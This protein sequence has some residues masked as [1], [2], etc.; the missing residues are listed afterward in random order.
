MRSGR[1]FLRVGEDSGDDRRS[2][3]N[4]VMAGSYA[5]GTLGGALGGSVVDQTAWAAGYRSRSRA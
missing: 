2:D 3:G 5:T 1:P 4:L